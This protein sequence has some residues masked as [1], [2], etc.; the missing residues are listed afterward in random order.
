MYDSVRG[1]KMRQPKL[2]S[3]RL[4][5]LFCFQPYSGMKKPFLLLLAYALTG[6]F[7]TVH[8]QRPAYDT[9]T[10]MTYNI[11]N[12]GLTQNG[13][14]TLLNSVKNPL[15]RTIIAYADP[16]I[17]GFEKMSISPSTLATDSIVR[18]VL[19]SACAGCYGYGDFT[20]FFGYSKENMLYYKTNKL[21]FI[22]TT[23]IYSGDNN[24]SDINLH[25]LYYKSP[26]L[27]ITRDTVFLNIIIVHLRSGS[28]NDAIRA[29]EISGVMNW[30]NSH[31]VSAGNYMAMGDF[32][33]QSSNESCFQ[34]LIN[35]ANS[36]TKFFDPVNQSGNW[37]N[38]TSSF[39]QYLTQSTRRIDPGDCLATGGM[40]N[41][42]DHILCTQVLMEGTDSLQYVTD[43][44]KVLGQ[45]GQHAGLAIT[46]APLNTSVPVNVLNA[47]YNMSEHLPVLVKLAVGGNTSHT[48]TSVNEATPVK[49]EYNIMASDLLTLTGD[50]A[51][52]NGVAKILDLQGRCVK[53]VVLGNNT[54][55]LIPLGSLCTGV[56]LLTIT[57]NSE[58]L[59]TGKFI[60]MNK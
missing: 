36:D 35:S 59:F 25:R 60:K 55:N 50:V 7:A 24:I 33:T 28:G 1:W 43:S 31:I 16:D 39:A 21:G 4:R 48:A 6:P 53:E 3:G 56:Y 34:Q 12:Y 54:H 14:P 23:T 5:I 20:G 37:S 15:L 47:L 13:C 22:S 27:S 46:D 29:S 30:L 8:A 2:S 52:D 58:P 11:G 41:R 10:V 26:T 18:F 19:D 49:W 45:D 42:F 51:L 32:N 9:L 57:S 38:N 40:V 44:Y 17:I